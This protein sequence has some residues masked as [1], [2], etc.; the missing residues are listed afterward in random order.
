M[1]LAVTVYGN[2]VL[3]KVAQNIDPDYADLEKLIADMFE[4]MYF[5]EGV[6]LAAPQIGRP[7]RLFIM[8]L[9]PM[10]EEHPEYANFKK[11]FINAEIV[12]RSGDYVTDEEGCLSVPGIRERVERQDRIR[13]KYQDENFNSYDEVYEGWAARVIQHEYDHI[14]GKLFVDFISPLRRRLIKGKLFAISKGKVDTKYRIR[15]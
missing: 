8:D 11:V 10:E 15:P 12:E 13:I 7:I 9:S 6:G 3:R 14:D 2:P 4:T 1:V 5:A